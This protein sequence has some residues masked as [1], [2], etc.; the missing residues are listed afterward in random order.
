VEK[1]LFRAGFFELRLQE[2][3]QHRLAGAGGADDEGVADVL[4]VEVEPEGRT[5]ARLQKR[6]RLTPMVSRLATRREGV[7]WAQRREIAAVYDRRPHPHLEVAG[8]LR[9]KCG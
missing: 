1:D 7:E 5:G 6:H 8:E 2:V 3:L 9:P 4:S